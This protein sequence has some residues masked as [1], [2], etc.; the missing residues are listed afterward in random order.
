M[1]GSRTD[2]F[3]PTIAANAN[4]S[5]MDVTPPPNA[6]NENRDERNTPRSRTNVP[7]KFKL[8]LIA[9]VKKH[10][11]IWQDRKQKKN[12]DLLDDAWQ[13]IR[14]ALHIK[15]TGFCEKQWKLL[16][17]GY[18]SHINR[19]TPMHV[20]LIR[21]MA[22]MAPQLKKASSDNEP[23][24]YEGEPGSPVRNKA[25]QQNQTPQPK[26][27]AQQNS[28]C[29]DTECSEDERAS[30]A[31]LKL[32]FASVPPDT[33]RALK[34]TLVETLNK[35]VPEVQTKILNHAKEQLAKCGDFSK[36]DWTTLDVPV[37]VSKAVWEHKVMKIVLTD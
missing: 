21:E 35:I 26:K 25:P 33:M 31:I 22:F 6:E 15:K 24:D 36:I 9:E 20:D 27:V 2:I 7:V 37:E 17:H 12:T 29:S 18:R 3:T 32:L 8:S 10:D 4:V 16:C 5:A 23:S 1:S 19:N 11:I 28:S 34:Q 30:V 14:K 13:K